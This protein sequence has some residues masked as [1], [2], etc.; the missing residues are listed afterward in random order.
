MKVKK[1]GI[2]SLQG[3]G[4]PLRVG[5]ATGLVTKR[6]SSFFINKESLPSFRFITVPKI[7]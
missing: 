4:A 1:R 5:A 3:V 7:I 2:P 6:S